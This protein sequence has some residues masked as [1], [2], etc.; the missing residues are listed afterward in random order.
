MTS[1]VSKPTGL[2]A[3][4]R[5]WWRNRRLRRAEMLDAKVAA[6]ENLRDFK[7]STGDL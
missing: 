5:E 6:H 7:R 3:A 2:W 1:P 4:I